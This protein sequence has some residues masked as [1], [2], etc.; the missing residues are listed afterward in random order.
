LLRIEGH[1]AVTDLELEEIQGAKDHVKRDEESER[2][3]RFDR[4]I[5]TADTA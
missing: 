5:P 3:D 2:V 4:Q 1:T